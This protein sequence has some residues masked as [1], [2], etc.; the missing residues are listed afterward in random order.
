MFFIGGLPFNLARN[1]H[2]LRSYSFAANNSLP[3]YI[4]PGYNKLRTTLLHQEKTNVELLLQPI[5]VT[6]KDKENGPTRKPLISFMATCGKGPM[7]LKAVNCFGQMKDKF[8]IANLVKEVI[9]EVGHQNV[10][11]IVTNNAT[12]CK[13]AGEIIESMYPHIYWTPCVVHT[14]NLALKNTCAAKNS[15]GNE[16]TFELCNL[17]TDIHGNAIQ[18][19]NFIMNHNMRLTIFNRFTP[20]RLLSVAYTYFASIIMMLK[21]F[22]LIKKGL[23]AMLISQEWRKVN[24]VKEKIVNDDWWD[25]IDYIIDFT[26]PIYDMIWVCDT[27]RPCLHLVYEMWDSMIEKVKLEIYKKEK[28]SHL[29]NCPF[30][31]AVYQV[32]I[33]RWTKSYTLLHCLAHSLNPRYYSDGWLHENH[34]KVAPYRD[35][36]ISR[37]RMKCF[38][39]LFPNSD[40]FDKMASHS[41]DP[42]NWWA[43]FGAKTY[44]LQSSAFKL[45][46]QPTSSSCCERNWSTYSFIHSLR[47]NRL[48]PSGTKNLVY[49][50]NNF[51]LL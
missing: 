50:H 31:D 10:V 46:G 21:R 2:Y 26:R 47:R 4:P 20:L 32:L 40:D 16:E 15:E 23:Q 12:N 37:E 3:G 8:F 7:F 29:E 9:D 45:L 35:A 18:I 6:W 27:D 34:S 41:S 44:F 13:G 42:R 49:I 1:P 5:K 43:N 38:Q 30:Y 24:F 14:L 19:K 22:K 48:N 51:H 11:Q 39:R 17:I 25:K 33:V 36:K 28:L